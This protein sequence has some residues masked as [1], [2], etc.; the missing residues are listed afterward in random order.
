M[1]NVS[2]ASPKS[3]YFSFSSAIH[4]PDLC[5]VMA[6][7]PAIILRG[8]TDFRKLVNS[9]VAVPYTHDNNNLVSF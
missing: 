5:S 6:D 9:S 3:P 2:G 7:L 1:K 8:V 4:S